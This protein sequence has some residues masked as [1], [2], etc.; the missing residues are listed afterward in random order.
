VETDQSPIIVE[1]D[2]ER[3]PSPSPSPVPVPAPSLLP[4]E[5]GTTDKEE[6]NR[7]SLS[8]PCCCPECSLAYGNLSW[9]IFSTARPLA[10]SNQCT[11]PDRPTAPKPVP[12]LRR[13][14]RSLL[15][16]MIGG[17]DESN[18]P[19]VEKDMSGC[20]HSKRKRKRISKD[21]I[22]SPRP[23]SSAV[24]VTLLSPCAAGLW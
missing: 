8:P 22:G 4:R 9:E 23:L 1:G 21:T 15:R 14:E 2:E 19:P 5:D 3:S 20:I 24:Q 13:R 7:G 10:P 17:D 11:K 6:E 18:T 16:R 12:L